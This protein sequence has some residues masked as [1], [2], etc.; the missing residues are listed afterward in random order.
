MQSCTVLVTKHVVC[1][2]TAIICTHHVINTFFY[3]Y[4]SSALP[5]SYLLASC[6]L[7]S[8]RREGC[9]ISI[10]VGCVYLHAYINYNLYAWCPENCNE[11]TL[12]CVSVQLNLNL[13][14]LIL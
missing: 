5:Q 6:E 3:F 8:C 7:S 11:Y 14:L 10:M 9:I 12:K 1:T 13:Y 2:Y 4:W